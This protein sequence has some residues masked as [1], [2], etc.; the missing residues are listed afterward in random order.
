MYNT[1]NG[2]LL[3]WKRWFDH[4]LKVLEFPYPNLS[5]E[6]KCWTYRSLWKNKKSIKKILDQVVFMTSTIPVQLISNHPW[7]LTSIKSIE[8]WHL[9]HQWKNLLFQQMKLILYFNLDRA[10]FQKWKEEEHVCLASIICSQIKF[11][12]MKVQQINLNLFLLKKRQERKK[13]Q[14]VWLLRERTKNNF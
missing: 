7:Q 2:V 6:H 4:I 10:D 3:W 5:L 14:K 1:I 13:I 9:T 11:Y 12:Q 8:K